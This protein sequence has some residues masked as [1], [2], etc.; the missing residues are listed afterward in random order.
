MVVITSELKSFAKKLNSPLY[1][2]GGYVRD[3]ILSGEKSKDIDLSG[4]ICQEEFSRA[5]KLHGFK[6]LAEYRHTGTV[7]FT[8]GKNRY[9]YTA[10]RRE[11]YQR[12]GNHVPNKVSFTTDIKQ[13]ALRRDFNCNALYLDVLSEEILDPLNK[14]LADI[15]NRVITTTREPLEVFKSDG[16]RLLRLARFASSL[17]FD[18]P[19]NVLDG[20][21]KNASN[22]LDISKERIYTELIEILN[23]DTKYS[24]SN[25]SG[26]YV[27]LKILE[28]INV[29]QAILPELCLGK[30]MAQ[31][32]DFHKYDVLEHTLKCV[33]YAPKEVRLS[34]LFHDVAK[35]TQKLKTGKFFGHE[36]VGETLVK[37]ILSRY[38][39]PKK[40]IDETAFLVRYHM[41]DL[42]GKLSEN[43]LKKF[44]VNNQ[45]FIPKLLA[46]KQADFSASKDDLSVCP[47]V[48]KWQNCIKKMQEENVPFNYK[49]MKLG[50]KDLISLGFSKEEIGKELQRLFYL[51]VEDA[52]N[53]DKTKLL[54]IAT[55]DLGKLRTN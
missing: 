39:A 37:G 6:I 23:S 24:F 46:L 30:N 13:D 20:A 11:D 48:I 42:D 19:P 17:N 54:N 52:K 55:A 26:H 21:R 18:I 33:Y 8:D 41:Y 50:A 31:R 22:I 38:K 40:V 36:K 2:V 32:P 15:K 25:K 12:G 53:N 9:E 43:K 14:G 10:F 44:I 4:A 5:L 3:Y 47:T 51:C 16:L 49:Q 29:L 34:A 27:G 35:P 28:N 45:K 7:V 1:A